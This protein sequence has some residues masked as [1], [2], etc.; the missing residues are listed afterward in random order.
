MTTQYVL[1]F[2]FDRHGAVALVEKKRPIWQ[3]GL[4]NGVGGHVERK[5]THLAAMVREFKEETGMDVPAKEWRYAGRLRCEGSWNCLVYTARVRALDLHTTT[6]ERVGVIQPCELN[7][8]GGRFT[9]GAYTTIENVPALIALCT[10]R[11]G[12]TGTV[13]E[14]DLDYTRRT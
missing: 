10:M 3:R 7:D 13:P 12:H 14:F 1:G 9:I 4:W 8:G 6:D 5:E 2:A 11:P